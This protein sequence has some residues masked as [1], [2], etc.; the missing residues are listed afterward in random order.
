MR[1]IYLSLILLLSGCSS[2]PEPAPF[3]KG[4]DVSVNKVS[5]IEKIVGTIK[6]TND[7]GSW[8]VTESIYIDKNTIQSTTTDLIKINYVLDHADKITLKGEFESIQRM[9][10]FIKLSRNTNVVLVPDCYNYCS[11]I[12]TAIFEKIKN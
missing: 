4:K 5:N 3:P 10:T 8:H 11:S 9:Q 1:F 6:N 7:N 12:V 2:P